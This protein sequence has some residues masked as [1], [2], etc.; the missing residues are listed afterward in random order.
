MPGT[1]V[2]SIQIKIL[3]SDTNAAQDSE[4]QQIAY[5]NENT[6]LL[7]LR[8]VKRYV[9][10]VVEFSSFSSLDDINF[11]LLVQVQIEEIISPV[12][13]D[14]TRNILNRFP[15][16][17]KIF[18]DSLER[19]TPEL[20]IPTTTAGKFVNALI[21]DSLD[22]ID[23]F[24]S[25]IELDSFID[26]ANLNEI[27]WLYLYPQVAPGFV[28]VLGDRVELSRVST[29]KELL[30]HRVTDYVFYYNY[31]TREL[32]TL[33]EFVS[34]KVDDVEQSSILVQ[35]INSFDEFGL[36]VGLQRLYLEPNDMFAK[37]ILDVAQNPP[38]INEEGLKLT[39]RRELDIWR[40]LGATPDSSYV[41][42]TPE[43]IELEDMQTMS[44]YFS[45][46]GIPTK[47]FY[48][49]VEYINVNYPSNFGYI[50]WGEAYWDYAGKK[51]EG[52]SSLP[53]ITD[54]ATP[55]SYAPVYQPGI[56]DFEDAKL[57]L[58]KVQ[59]EINNY[60]FGLRVKGLKYDGY[61][62]AYEPISIKYDSYL[63]YLEEYVDNETATVN[64]EVTLKLNLHGDIPND[65]V[66]KASYNAK[67]KNLQDQTY[68]SSP[69]FIVKSIFNP[70][71]FT[72]GESI[73][74]DSSGTPYI[75][76]F[77]VSATE[78]YTFS[79]IPLYSVDEAT[80]SFINSTDPLGSNGDYAWLGFLDATPNQL[81]DVSNPAIVKTAE[82]IND[83]SYAL[84]LK[85]AS[86]IYDAKKIREANTPKV[87]SDRFGK[88]INNSSNI[89]QQSP[90]VFT[91][92]E[93]LKDIVVPYGAIPQYV[94]IENV[95]EDSYDI[96]HSSGLY[97]GYGGISKNRDTDQ[98]HLIPSSPNIIFSYVNPNFSTPELMPNFVDM[99]GATANYYFSEIKFPYN[100]TPDYLAISSRDS[101]IYPFNTFSWEEFSANYN[102]EI[103]FYIGENGIIQHYSPENYDLTDSYNGD[104]VGVFD[105]D[106]SDFGL[107]NYASSDNL[108]IYE[109][110]AVNENDDVLIYPITKNPT[111]S[112]EFDEELSL[113]VNYDNNFVDQAMW[114]NLLAR[115]SA[116]PSGVLNYQDPITGRY[117]IK[118][119][120]IYA[121][122]NDK[123]N[124]YLKPSIKTGWYYQNLQERYIY[125]DPVE[126]ISTP[127]ADSLILGTVARQGAPII[128]TVVN[129][130][131]GATVDYSRVSFTDEATPTQ[132][133]Y[134][135][136]EYISP[137]HENYLAL[138][139]AD[140]FDVKIVDQFTGQTVI[141]NETFE[142]NVI[143]YTNSATP[144]LHKG[145]Q[146]RV[147]YRVNNS[148][149][150][151]NEYYNALDNSYRTKINL[152][153]TPSYNYYVSATY[154][155][156]KYD[157]DYELDDVFLNPLYSPIDRGFLYL[158]HNSYELGSVEA[159]ISP[160]N[161][162]QGTNDFMSLNIWSKDINENPKPY[163]SMYISG[164]DTEATPSVTFT[165]EDGYRKAYLRHT[166]PA[167]NTPTIHYVYITSDD[168]DISATISYRS[169]P[170][171]VETQKLSAE[172]TKKI[173]NA[174]GQ[175]TQFVYG[176]ATPNAVVYWRK[177]RTLYEALN[178]PYD[179][180]FSDPGQVQQQ[181]AVLADSSGNFKIG[182][183][184]AQNDAT[185]GYWFVVVDSEF[186]QTI[187][188]PPVT[189]VGDIVYW[190]E[191][192]DVN[193]SSSEE[194]VLTSIGETETEYYHYLTNPVFK[195]DQFTNVAYYEDVYSDS[196]NLPAWY[197]ISRYTQY[198]MG[199]LG[200]TPYV[201]D[202]Y[203]LLRP[204]YEEE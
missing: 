6:S 85:I 72:N 126:E 49:F 148:F 195:K 161:V 201:V 113:T 160:K 162:V 65:A 12:I 157:D 1:E 66:Y 180:S 154:E 164:N 26:S 139:Y 14:H 142:N 120:K 110:S 53:Q 50:K 45:K 182:P 36:R 82:E 59:N 105:L 173:V 106:R 35:T 48:D 135:N 175:E 119:L 98:N 167:T 71:G 147:S 140:V 193:Q 32:Y 42:A 84:N 40:A 178:L 129:Y 9:K 7:F 185:P 122:Y 149:N 144:I 30:E 190:Y 60:S 204:D 17:T 38:S 130:E 41:G 109:I 22:K 186:E 121:R 171:I 151:D 117:I 97:F 91:P 57:K 95:V 156:A 176:S 124:F 183:Y 188:D 55:E 146:Y 77:N 75:N 189:I 131:T 58:E 81:A 56:G 27:A 62:A 76:T 2:P 88:F 134:Y 69:E 125:A 118:G 74:Y 145:R 132:L 8:D 5:I 15:S 174:D 94:H 47:S 141:E 166:G 67:V 202:S 93:I 192:Y 18:S 46:D 128:T 83:S 159:D 170:K 172:V 87:R 103:E 179:G 127:N 100:S 63:S 64:Y 112:S 89:E 37:R 28:K 198:Q 90:L 187:S 34:L 70:A 143:D 21:G 29:M 92:Q 203:N 177:A 43:I 19:S 108:W 3:S 61:E 99:V 79:E 158:S 168:P 133:S 123:N 155:S 184:I 138:A 104:L 197:P 194:P 86:K 101:N 102:S 199:I 20:A 33:R 137:K 10:F 11:L 54:A 114:S 152:L 78:S 4:W 16:W 200:A 136:Y 51:S 25:R 31:L 68:D 23:E 107:A 96:D 52:V 24:I 196:W 150:V 115:D 73:Y 80:I 116:T 191:R 44:E 163:T 181:G 39:L 165:N 13:S 169:I 153:S 111:I